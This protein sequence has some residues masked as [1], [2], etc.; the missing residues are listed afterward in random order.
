MIFEEIEYYKISDWEDY[1]ISKCGKVLSTKGKKPRILKPGTDKKGYKNVD[2]RSNGKRNTLKIHRLVAKAFLQNY[3]ED[4]HV[5]H[6]N[7]VKT[8]NNLTNLRMVTV[9][10]NNRNVL[11][12]VGVRKSLNKKQGT[13]RYIAH[14][15]D[16][17]GKICTKSFAVNKYGEE[18]AHQ[19]ATEVR[20]EMVTKYYNRPS[21]S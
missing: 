10:E 4:L 13:Y 17:A 1:Y 15:T 2:L 6:K 3:T 16:D 18:L 8:N 14:W 20:Q 5:D 9:S 11:K 19:K 12:F 7:N 21:L